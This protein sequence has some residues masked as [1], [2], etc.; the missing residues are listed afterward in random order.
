MNQ[1]ATAAEEDGSSD[2]AALDQIVPAA[3]GPKL[4]KLHGTRA[5]GAP[6]RP[7]THVFGLPS[8]ASATASS[9]RAHF[10]RRRLIGTGDVGRARRKDEPRCRARASAAASGCRYSAA[11]IVADLARAKFSGISRAAALLDRR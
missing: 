9:L 6:T 2:L 4:R 7:K 10:Q 3:R 11:A 1:K 5:G 8:A